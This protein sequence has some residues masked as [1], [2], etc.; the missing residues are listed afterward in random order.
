MRACIVLTVMALAIS[1]V[2]LPSTA[3]HA[4]SADVSCLGSETVT[5]QPGLSLVPQAVNVT[6]RGTLTSCGSSDPAITSGTYLQRFT[7]TLSCDTLLAGLAGT[8]DLHWSNGQSSSFS[9]NRTINDVAG[10]TTV[11]FAG[12]IGSGRFAGDTAIEQAAFVTLNPLQCLAPEGLTT[13]GPGAAILTI[14]GI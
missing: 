13:L 10:Q 1:G 11:T 12:T 7:A 9:Y 4:L 5:Y 2:V 6:V 3:A 14:D 8:R